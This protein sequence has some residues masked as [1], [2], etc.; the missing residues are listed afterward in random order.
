MSVLSI[1]ANK[2]YRWLFGLCARNCLFGLAQFCSIVLKNTKA[3]KLTTSKMLLQMLILNG[4]V[5][6][7]YSFNFVFDTLF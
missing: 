5:R 4:Y 6:N 2:C 3:S 1:G 7:S